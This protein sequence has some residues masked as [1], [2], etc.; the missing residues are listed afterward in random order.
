MVESSKFSSRDRL[1]KRGLSLNAYGIVL[2]LGGIFLTILISSSASIQEFGIGFIFSGEWDPIAQ[3]YGALPFIVGTLVSSLLAL[4]ISIPFSL[5]IALLLGEYSPKG[6]IPS[7]VRSMIE[8]MAGVPS[9]IYGF[10][11]LMFLVPI[12][13]NIE[14]SLMQTEI[15]QAMEILP[16]GVGILASSIIL[17]IMII[18]YSSSVAR[19]VITMVPRNLK[20]AAYSLGSTRFEVITKVVLPYARSGIIAG[21]LLSLGRAI[22]ETM[23]VTMLIGNNNELPKNIFSPANTMASVIANEFAEAAEGVQLAALFEIGLLLF[24]ISVIINIIGRVIIRKM[25]NQGA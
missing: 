3:V 5:A 10:W 24:I 11:G 22:G 1:F 2:L 13:R 9:V 16:Y 20:E 12:I 15:G 8:L 19:E 21:V 17:A 6:I 25:D 14:I 23:A 7:F 18:P 4:A